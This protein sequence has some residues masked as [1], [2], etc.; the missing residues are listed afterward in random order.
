[1]NRGMRSAGS[2]RSIKKF[3]QPGHSINWVIKIIRSSRE[4]GQQGL[5][6]NGVSRVSQAMMSAGSTGD[7]VT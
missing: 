2:A 7:V 5:Q 1:M 6:K 3:I 4:W